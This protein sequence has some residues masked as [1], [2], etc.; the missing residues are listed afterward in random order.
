MDLLAAVSVVSA[1]AR[2]LFEVA[3][4]SVERLQR[5]VAA[6]QQSVAAERSEA[7]PQRSV[8]VERSEAAPR[9]SEVAHLLVVAADSVAARFAEADSTVVADAVPAGTVVAMEAD[10][11]ADVAKFGFELNPG[12]SATRGAAPPSDRRASRGAPGSR[13]Q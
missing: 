2:L 13:T 4:V 11:A 1:A 3:E 8:G 6:R 7:A 12:A 10:T 5:F 9:L